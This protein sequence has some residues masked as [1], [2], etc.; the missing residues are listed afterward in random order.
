MRKLFNPSM[1]EKIQAEYS[2]KDIEVLEGLES[3]RKRPGMYI[4]GTDITALHHLAVEIIDNSID[5]ALAGHADE[6]HISLLQGNRLQV[7]DNGR[8]IPTDEH[9]KFPGKSALEIITTTLHSGGKFKEGAYEVSGGLHGVGLSVVNALSDQLQISVFR[10]DKKYTQS[11]SKGL[12]TSPI[13]TETVKKKSQGTLIDFHPDPEIFDEGLIFIPATLFNIARSKA[14][15]VPGVKI[16]W[17][18]EVVNG[19][20]TLRDAVFHFPN[21]LKDFLET[22]TAG[23]EVLHT[24]AANIKGEGVKLDWALS[25]LNNADPFFKSYCNTI[26][27]PAGGTHET[28]FR[29]GLFKSIKNFGELLSDKRVDKLIV[30]DIFSEC[31][32]VISAF[33]KNPQFQGQTKEKLVSTFVLKLLETLVRDYFD[34][35]FIQNKEVSQN[36]LQYFISNAERRLH[37]KEIKNIDR[38]SLTKRVRLP[39]KLIDCSKDTAAGTEIFIVEGDSAGGSA[40][41]ARLRESQAILPLRGKIMNVMTSSSDK[42][43]LNQE[44][45]VLTQALGCG[46]GKQCNVSKL[47]YERVIIMTDADVDGAHIASLLMVFFFQHMRS[48]VENGQL[49]LAQPPLYKLSS[50]STTVYAHSDIE[51]DELL[52]TVFKKTGNVMVNRFKGLGEMNPDQLKHTTMDPKKRSLTRVLIK[53]TDTV[54]DF[55]ERVMGKEVAPRLQYIEENALFIKSLED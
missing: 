47:R 52:K 5:E 10:G 48:I 43:A 40:K 11:Y 29:N 55:V 9:P 21:G 13:N 7:R 32:C 51:R 35:Y 1:T 26:N 8:G 18:S 46:S 54:A 34:H 38:A 39:G 44:I 15:L 30:E 45:Q 42:V 28:A 49:Y 4:G 24:V 2:A 14:Y 19:E 17:H 53:E 27:T 37:R 31:S 6:I 33:I 22:L 23:Q 36:L 20:E 3:V 16:I 50:G 25:W 12:V 41:Q